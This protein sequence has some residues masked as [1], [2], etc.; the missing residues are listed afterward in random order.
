[1]SIKAK[2][3]LAHGAGA[4]M[5][6]DF[7]RQMDDLLKERGIE[8]QRFNFPY[9][10]KAL[11]ENKKRPPNPMPKLIEAFEQQVSGAGGELPLFVGGKSM[12]ARVALSICHL[13]PVR[14]AIAL[15]YPLHPPGK[16]EK[17]RLE[18]LQ[19]ADK[20]VLIVQGE[21]D[22]FGNREDWQNIELEA[23]LT[24]SFLA[25]GD[26]SLKPRKRSGYDYDTHMASAA[27]CISGFIN[28]QLGNES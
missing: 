10:Q 28:Q 7:M 21:R 24:L 20:P 5:E 4:G 26:H 9:M 15:G 17:L 14:G 16:P 8:V 22:T 1:M 11:E 12:G 27:D 18:P 6:S 13:S 3:I 2:L 25:D 19:Q 23:H